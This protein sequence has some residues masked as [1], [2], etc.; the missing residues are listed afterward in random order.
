MTPGIDLD[1]FLAGLAL[2]AVVLVVAWWA[3]VGLSVIR[4]MLD[5]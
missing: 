4:R 5:A 1:A 2:A 3:S